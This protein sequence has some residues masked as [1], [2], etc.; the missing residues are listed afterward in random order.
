MARERSW[1]KVGCGDSIDVWKD[2]WLLFKD[3]HN[4]DR[5]DDRT[6]TPL[7][8]SSLIDPLRM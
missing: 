4:V 7:R 1:W 5:V 3:G 6:L 2:R 8:M